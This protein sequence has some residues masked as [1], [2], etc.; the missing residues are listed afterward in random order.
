VFG[1]SLVFSFIDV[2][3]V[4]AIW[5]WTLVSGKERLEVFRE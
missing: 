1:G 3:I 5:A 4:D 2:V